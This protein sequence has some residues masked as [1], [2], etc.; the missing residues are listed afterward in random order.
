MSEG[1][2]AKMYGSLTAEE[3]FRLIMAASGRGDEAEAQRLAMAGEQVTFRT[4][5]HAPYAFA[6]NEVS[7]L[8]LLELVDTAASYQEAL[9]HLHSDE[10][11]ADDAEEANLDHEPEEDTAEE[12]SGEECNEE[13]ELDWNRPG[14]PRWLGAALGMGFMLKTK[15][16]GWKLFCERMGIPPF[17]LWKGLPGFDR[18]QRALKGA[19]RAAFTPKGMIRFLNS[20]RPEGEPEV[21]PARLITVE[22]CADEAEATYRKRAE[23]WGA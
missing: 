22:K 12:G 19:E 3:R 8:T 16:D 5:A 23:W 6:F 18:L 2:L 10:D 20:I 21:D 17:L 15:A 4:A 9:L 1:S 13:F 11:E 7:E 14:G